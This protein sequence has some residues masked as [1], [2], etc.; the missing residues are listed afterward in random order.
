MGK[1]KA[2]K[3][4]FV[5]LIRTFWSRKRAVRGFK[6]PKDFLMSLADRIWRINPTKAIVYNTLKDVYCKADMIAYQRSQDDR[7]FFRE[8]QAREFE[9]DWNAFK[10]S[11]DD[12]IHLKSNTPKTA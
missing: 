11:V 10:D 1:K 2:S 3:D 6:L 12:M 9:K 5:N 8:S 7:K 4:P